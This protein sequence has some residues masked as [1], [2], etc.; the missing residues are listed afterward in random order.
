MLKKIFLGVLSLAILLAIS[1]MAGPKASVDSLQGEY[2]VVPSDLKSL[3]NLLR[4]KEDTVQGLKEGNKAKIIWANPENP[5]KTAYSFLYIH[6]FGASSREG[7]PVHEAIANHYNANLY[8]LRLPE[9]GIDRK[10]AMRYMTAEL[11]VQEVREAYMLAQQ[12]GEEVIVIGT[13]MG[14]ALALNLASERP[15]IKALVL[16]SPAIRDYGQKLEQFFQPWAAYMAEKFIFEDGVNIVKRE[17]EKAQY[18]SEQYHI[19]GYLSLAVLLKSK[20]T[21]ETFERIHQPVFMGYYYKDESAQDFV[22][23]VKAMQEMFEQLGTPSD[24]KV[25]K[26]FPETAD[27]VIASDLTSKD[28]ENVLKSSLEF[29]DAIVSMK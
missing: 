4:A 9:H 16:Y 24:K 26:A 8:L 18:W 29:L 15:E 25:E 12:L 21:K 1:Y 6:G 2:P 13:S 14:G 10:D 3:E 27:H 28:W 17:G 20:M 22:V 5:Q 23:S 7:S 19:N 11:L